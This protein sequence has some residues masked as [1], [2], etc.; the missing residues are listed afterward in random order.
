MFSWMLIHLHACVVKEDLKDFEKIYTGLNFWQLKTN[1]NQEWQLDFNLGYLIG[2]KDDAGIDQIRWRYELINL[3]KNQLFVKEE[4]MRPADPKR[5]QI[6]VNGTRSRKDIIAYPLQTGDR[7]VLWFK[8]LYRDQIIH[9]ALYE[10][11]AG[12]KGENRN[13]VD[14]ILENVDV[15]NIRTL[16]GFDLGGLENGSEGELDGGTQGQSNEG[17]DRDAGNGLD[18]GDQVLI[19]DF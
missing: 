6:F 7:Y 10:L 4:E 14:E 11:V 13:W 15:D 12:E 19:R 18:L 3:R 8:F 1:Q 2:L 5:T 9:E 17:N 16:E